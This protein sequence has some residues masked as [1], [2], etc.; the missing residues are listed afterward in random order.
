LMGRAW[1]AVRNRLYRY[2]L[3]AWEGPLL[4]MARRSAG[5]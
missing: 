2:L 3:L 5:P 1:E 4:L